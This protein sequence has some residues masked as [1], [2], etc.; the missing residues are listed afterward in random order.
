[1]PCIEDTIKDTKKR[2]QKAPIKN[3]PQ[4]ILG[5]LDLGQQF[6]NGGVRRPGST[7]LAWLSVKM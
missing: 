2:P 6:D 7:R 1:V 5:I 4:N 3:A